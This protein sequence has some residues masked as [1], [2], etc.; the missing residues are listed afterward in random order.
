LLSLVPA[1]LGGN[2][3]VASVLIANNQILGLSITPEELNTAIN[4][5][6]LNT[7][8]SALE[9]VSV[10]IFDPTCP[11]NPTSGTSTTSTS[12]TVAISTSSS[13]AGNGATTTSANAATTTSAATTSAGNGA[14]TTTGGAAATTTTAGSSPTCGVQIALCAGQTLQDVGLNEVACDSGVAGVVCSLVQTLEAA[15]N[16]CVGNCQIVGRTGTVGLDLDPLTGIESIQS[17]Q[18]AVD[19][20]PNCQPGGPTVTL[21]EPTCPL[22]L[23]KRTTR[24][25]RF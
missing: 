20:Y 23:F 1:L 2:P 11:A 19:N 21:S 3:E 12:T 24:Y 17:V 10:V 8:C 4:A 15:T 5:G 22:A 18:A 16:A 13:S 9:T 25:G 7:V 14:T 6:E